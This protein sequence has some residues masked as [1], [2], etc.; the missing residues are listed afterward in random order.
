MNTYWF[1]IEIIVFI[2]EAMLLLDGAR[3]LKSQKEKFEQT[4]KNE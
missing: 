2:T 1:K 4:Q 3:R